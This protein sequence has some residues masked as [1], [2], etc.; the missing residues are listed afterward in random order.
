M[1][2]RRA[3]LQEDAS[4][5]AEQLRPLLGLVLDD[6]VIGVHSQNVVLRTDR[7]ERTQSDGG[8]SGRRRQVEGEQGKERAELR[9]GEREH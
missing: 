2:Y 8:V 3:D 4:D 7:T 1:E 6:G 5:A 9:R